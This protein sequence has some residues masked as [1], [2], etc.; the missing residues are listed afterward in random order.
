MNFVIIYIEL[1]YVNSSICNSSLFKL[2][3]LSKSNKENPRVTF[4]CQESILNNIIPDNNSYILNLSGEPF[5]NNLK[6]SS[7]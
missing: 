6:I 3:L 4:C 2:E 1:E 7:L 5:A